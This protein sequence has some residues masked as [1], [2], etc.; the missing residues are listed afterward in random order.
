MKIHFQR[1]NYLI[2]LPCLCLVCLFPIVESRGRVG[3]IFTR[4]KLLRSAVEGRAAT[5]TK[6]PPMDGTKK[7]ATRHRLE[8]R[9][10]QFSFWLSFFHRCLFTI[11]AYPSTVYQRGFGYLTHQKG[12]HSYYN[13]SPVSN[14]QQ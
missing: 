9:Y 13:S 2:V 1:R 12:V 5:L 10:M 8:Q 4:L 7:R 6:G 3:Q 14:T 11:R